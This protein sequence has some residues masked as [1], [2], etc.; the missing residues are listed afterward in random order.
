MVR[1]IGVAGLAALTFA[2][3]GGYQKLKVDDV[4]SVAVT[5]DEPEQR[6]CAYAPV[7]LR[8]RVTYKN[9]DTAQ[10]QTP[11]EGRKGRLRPAEFQW[12]SAFGTIDDTAVLRLAPDP[13]AW[14]EQPIRVSAKVAARPEMFGATELAPRFDCGGTLDLKGAKGARGGEL[15]DG[16]AGAPGPVVDVALAYVESPRRG[17]LVLVRVAR[18]GAPPEFFVID[19]T[20]GKSRS[21]STRAVATAGVAVKESRGST[22]RPAF[23]VHRARAARVASRQHRAATARPARRAVPA[24]RERTAA[25]AARADA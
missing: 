19:A 11:G 1:A 24:A 4:K 10:T 13:F 15:E 16:G 21:S 9:G 23:Q 3:C 12:V 14:L 20:N 2:A 25:R 17:R 5:I 6:F 8:A 22:A 18:E 7:E